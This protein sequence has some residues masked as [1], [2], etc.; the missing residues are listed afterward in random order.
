MEDESYPRNVT[1]RDGRQVLV[2]PMYP[3]DLP[4]M[5]S[6]FADLP[7]EDRQFLRNDVRRPEVVERFV[8][9][10]PQNHL[11]AL[12]A[13]AEGKIVGSATL[14]RERYGWMTH[15]GELRLVFARSHQHQ[16]L[17]TTFVKLL[18]RAA[19][20][21]HIEKIV[22]H[23]MDGQFPAQ[24]GLEGLGFRLEARLKGFAL[25]A[26]G[27]KRDLLLYTNDVSHIW[28][29]MEA[30]VADFSPTYGG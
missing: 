15:I 27:K 18:T 19:L 11:L 24:K 17:G 7:D 5:I 8:R 12:V 1:L 3:E 10:S 29:R 13:E 16:G 23:I 4:R 21:S 22:A 25:D 2:R 9:E 14:Q 6:F 26:R 30:L 28:E 20:S